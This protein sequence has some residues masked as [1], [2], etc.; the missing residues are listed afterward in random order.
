MRLSIFKNAVMLLIWLP[1][2]ACSAHP[3]ERALRELQQMQARDYFEDPLQR[4]LIEAVEGRD[5]SKVRTVLEQGADVNAVGR[6]GMTPLFWALAKQNLDGF[7][8]LLEAGADPNV[9]VSLPEHFQ[10]PKA[11]AME[12]AARLES[13]EYLRALLESGGNPN[14]IVNEE[15]QMPVLYRAI[16]SRR[17]NNVETL[18][19]HGADINH[20]D[21]SG[22]TP[23]MQS[24]TARQFEIALFLLRQGADPTIEVNT[25]SSVIDFVRKYSDRGIDTRT[26][27]LAAYHDFV[28][29][30]RERGL[31]E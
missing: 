31:L 1:L 9:V 29:E 15:W 4:A 17:L 8:V 27:D 30:L 26:N 20:Q 2:T 7:K 19:E 6:E 11:G 10:E 24:V 14:T 5:A 12:M 13:T 23:L 22:A 18:L 21:K 25:G 28:G 3:E 16:M